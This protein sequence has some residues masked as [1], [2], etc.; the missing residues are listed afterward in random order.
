[1]YCAEAFSNSVS[2]LT[3]DGTRVVATLAVGS[4]PAVLLSISEYRELYVGCSESRFVYVIKDSV[5][6]IAENGHPMRPAAAHVQAQPS[7]FRTVTTLTWP[8]SGQDVCIYSQT[9]V[10]VRML[11][12]LQAK[13]EHCQVRWD[14]RDERGRETPAGVYFVSTGE[15]VSHHTKVIKLQ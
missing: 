10:L 11:T 6:G 15:R 14:G 13:A 3:G 4:V 1:V 2:V 12:S 9:G 5:T 7:M 8:G